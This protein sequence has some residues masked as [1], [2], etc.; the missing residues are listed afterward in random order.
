METLVHFNYKAYSLNNLQNIL[1]V[2]RLS[3]EERH[4]I[5]VVAN[6]LPF[7][8]NNYVINEMINWDNIPDDPIYRLTFPHR[9]MLHPEHFTE[10][11]NALRRGLNK[12]ELKK[13]A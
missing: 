5:E 7:K 8:T 4:E 6:V 1:Q 12:A 11:E 9:D 10:M 13:V 2:E 3:E